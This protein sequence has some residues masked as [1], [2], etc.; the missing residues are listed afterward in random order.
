MH[1]RLIASGWLLRNEKLPVIQTFNGRPMDQP[2]NTSKQQ[3]IESRA[4]DKKDKLM[5]LAA[6][7]MTSQFVK[8]LLRK[9]VYLH[10]ANLI[11]YFLQVG[12][13]NS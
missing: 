10:V 7:Q 4:C 12:V 1:S 3:L 2:T 11:L 6:Y 9:H 13:K 5:R 8:L